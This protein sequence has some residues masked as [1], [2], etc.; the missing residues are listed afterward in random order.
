MAHIHSPVLSAAAQRGLL[1]AHQQ[2]LDAA[3]REMDRRSAE[4]EDMTGATIDPADYSIT[5]AP[6]VVAAEAAYVASVRLS[7]AQAEEAPVTGSDGWA[8]A[9]AS[10]AAADAAGVDWTGADV[11]YGDKL[12]ENAAAYQALLAALTAA[13]EAALA[14]ID[15][16]GAVARH[17]AAS[18]AALAAYLWATGEPTALPQP[19]LS[20]RF[21]ITPMDVLQAGRHGHGR[22]QAKVTG[23]WSRDS[24][25]IYV[26]RKEDW[27]GAPEL[28][29][30]KEVSQHEWKFTVSHASGGRDEK[31]VADDLAAA[32]NFGHALTAMAEY[33]TAMRAPAVTTILER[34]WQEERAVAQAKADAERDAKQARA[35][36]DKA[37]GEHQAKALLDMAIGR[38][39]YE[40]RAVT[41]SAFKRGEDTAT[42]WSVNESR[43]GITQ[44]F[45]AGRLTPRKDAVQ[46]LSLMSVRTA[47]A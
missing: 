11:G 18:E 26:D 43:G 15:A 30:G 33:A 42:D 8:A 23:Y 35:D 31:V 2:N 27:T 20:E 46:L 1:V 25:T 37:L 47:V 38:M 16:P 7:E 13:N 10:M 3:Q 29:L 36:A 39:K 9:E 14:D 28:G 4:G 6:A 34:L 21:E 17:A 44:V 12:E 40:R 24:I 22:A 19:A 41:I 5:R 45:C 32:L